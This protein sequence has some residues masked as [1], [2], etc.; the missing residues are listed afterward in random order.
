[1]KNLQRALFFFLLLVS[2]QA[3]AQLEKGNLLIGG[4][5]GFNIQFEDGDNVFNL[6]LTPNVAKL[7]SDNLALGGGLGVAYQK[8]GDFSST[9]LTILPWG[10]FYIP[11]GGESPVFFLDAKAGLALASFKFDDEDES[12]SAFAY[13]VGPGM[14]FFITDNVSIDAILA[15]TRIGGDF[16][17]SALGLNIGLQV[18]LGGGKE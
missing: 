14:A 4:T 5:A 7:I 8:I 17:S 6:E 9:A 13:S 2:I 10:R 15:Y 16:D 18:F 1:M 12:E 3:T 11:T